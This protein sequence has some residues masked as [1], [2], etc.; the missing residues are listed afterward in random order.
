MQKNVT[1]R[2]LLN[3]AEMIK[4]IIPLCSN[5]CHNPQTPAP[6]QNFLGS[7]FCCSNIPSECEKLQD[8]A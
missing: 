8:C 5:L 2:W 4:F 3:A 7:D 1:L 6:K